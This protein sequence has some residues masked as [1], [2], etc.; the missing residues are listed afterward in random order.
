MVPPARKQAISWDPDGIVE[1]YSPMAEAI[2]DPACFSRTSSS[3]IAAAEVTDVIIL[4]Y[5][6]IIISGW[7]VDAEVILLVYSASYISGVC[8]VDTSTVHPMLTLSFTL[9]L[10]PFEIVSDH[11]VLPP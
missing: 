1:V 5:I 3:F 10:S 9:S 11:V 6:Y 2:I 8:S 7:M 4:N